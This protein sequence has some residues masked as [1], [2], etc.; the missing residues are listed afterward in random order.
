MQEVRGARGIRCMLA[1]SF[2]RQPDMPPLRPG[3]TVSRDRKQLVSIAGRG[4]PSLSI[5]S[6]ARGTS[7]SF[8]KPKFS[9]TCQQS[10]PSEVTLVRLS[11]PT[12]GTS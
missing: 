3:T 1:K 7:G 6:S 11:I 5:C 2:S 8:L 4:T 12:Q 10:C 9:V